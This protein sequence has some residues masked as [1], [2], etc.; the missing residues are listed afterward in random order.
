MPPPWNDRHAAIH[1]FNLH[2]L[3]SAAKLGADLTIAISRFAP[4][5]TKGNAFGNRPETRVW[6]IRV[7]GHG[8]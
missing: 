4:D 6:F 2:N 1:P 7:W 3:V 8:P 5:P